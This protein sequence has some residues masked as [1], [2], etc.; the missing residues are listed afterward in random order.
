[1]MLGLLVASAAACDEGWDEPSQDGGLDQGA[2]DP[3]ALD[4]LAAEGEAAASGTGA[5]LQLVSWVQD[6]EVVHKVHCEDFTTTGATHCYCNDDPSLTGSINDNNGSSQCVMCRWWEW[7]D[8]TCALSS[9]SDVDVEFVS[10]GSSMYTYVDDDQITVVPS[11]PVTAPAAPWTLSHCDTESS[12]TCTANECT[13]GE[14]WLGFSTQHAKGSGT[15]STIV[16]G[17]IAKIQLGTG[18]CE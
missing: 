15:T 2:S 4:E 7:T 6:G 8:G 1:M 11:G 17:S 3:M 16:A 9:S 12:C 13:C 14:G 18:S 5:T 10:N